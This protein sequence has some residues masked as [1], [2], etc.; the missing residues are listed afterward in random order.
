[1]FTQVFYKCR[2]CPGFKA[3]FP[4]VIIIC[5]FFI[6]FFFF[7]TGHNIF[8]SFRNNGWVWQSYHCV[9]SRWSPLPG[10]LNTLYTNSCT[11]FTLN[12]GTIYT[13]QLYTLYN[14]AVHFTLHSGT[15]YTTQWYTLHYTVVHFTLH[16]GSLYTTQ[17]YTL[18]YTVVFFTI[19]SGTLYTT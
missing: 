1:M 12:N 5:Y 16:T 3:N 8:L 13:T 9:F 19:L 4:R 6:R 2:T 14:I 15:L 11:H 10:T 18:H 17:W 7:L